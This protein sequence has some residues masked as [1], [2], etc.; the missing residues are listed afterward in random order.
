MNI[1]LTKL[2]EDTLKAW[3]DQRAR[4]IR[5]VTACTV[6]KEAAEHILDLVMKFEAITRHRS[7]IL[8]VIAF[9]QDLPDIED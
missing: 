3:G 1:D 2:E 9:L 4:I 7:K 5:A 8:N 6:S